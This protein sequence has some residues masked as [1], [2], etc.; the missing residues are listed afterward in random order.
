MAGPKSGESHYFC[1]TFGTI[2]L[3][4]RKAPRKVKVHGH[5]GARA[6]RPENTIA[7]FEYA[8]AAGVD[9]LEL[10]LGVTRDGVVVVSHE[11]YLGPP[12]CSGP[13]AKAAIRKMSLA[14]VKRWDCG[15]VQHPDFP[16]QQTAP[17]SRIPTLDEV[18]AL[19]PRGPV[20]FNMETKI[21]PAQ[22]EL[23][24]EPE[25]FVRLV[26]ETIRKHGLESRV[27]L[28]SF[29]FR[30]LHAMKKLVPA[31]RL[32]ALYEGPSR[33]FVEIAREAG[34]HIVSPVFPLVT[35]EQV[36]AAHA[37]GLEVIPWTANSSAEWDRLI[38]AG[39]DGIITDDPGA[40]IAHLGG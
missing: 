21:F 26:L 7:A 18:L 11:P 27:I 17:G 24:P 4:L 1:R 40:L 29:D 37:Q 23:A 10:D 8:I 39:V 28:Q 3:V 16:R 25:E 13:Q 34:A 31:I 22:P 32:S 5:R 30:T 2:L 14:E 33:N 20:H 36:T 6:V 35:P 15:S 38:A 12:L 19:A 9:V